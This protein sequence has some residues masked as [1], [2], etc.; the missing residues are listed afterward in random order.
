MHISTRLAHLSVLVAT[1]LAAFNAHARSDEAFMKQAA[2]NGH[3]EIQAS[4][5]AVTKARNADVKAYASTMV[6][7]HTKVDDELK[8]LASSK[9]V[10]LPTEPSTLQKAEL[11]M[12]SAGDDAKFDQRYAKSFG[13]KAHEDTVK[14]FQEAVQEAKDPEVKAFAQKTLP[15]L[16][17]HLEMAKALKVPSKD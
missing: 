10:E 13:I 4:K 17:H 5:L 9:K 7:D 14:L 16:Q 15:S 8:Q 12:I 11:K 1:G 6:A 3:A 2:Q